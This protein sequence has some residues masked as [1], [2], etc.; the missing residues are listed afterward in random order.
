MAR[1]AAVRTAPAS[2]VVA[3]S[4][5]ILLLV[6]GWALR[7]ER[8]LSAGFGTGYALG[9]IGLGMMTLLLLYSLR[10]HVRLLSGW[11]PLRTWFHTHMVLGLLGP[12]AVILH[13]NFELGSINSNVVLLCT[14]LVAGSGIIGRVVYT[15]IHVELTGRRRSLAEMRKQ[16]QEAR[17]DLEEFGMSPELRERLDEVERCVAQVPRGWIGALT[18]FVAIG[19]K[20]RAAAR[21]FRAGPTAGATSIAPFLVTSRRVAR[22]AIYERFFSLWHAFHLPICVLL[23]ASAVVHVFA[24][25]SY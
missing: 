2:L 4:V 16:M 6:G 11:G 19:T 15:R 10:K 24:V 22:F 9:V 3:S 1:T 25:H 5:C 18:R 21:S 23:F 13:C 14:L 17:A 12:T 8:Y 20:T 7:D